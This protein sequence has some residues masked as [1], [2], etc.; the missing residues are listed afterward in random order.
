M[1]P[2]DYDRNFSR[3]AS[4]IVVSFR[5]E[6]G[7]EVETIRDRG[8]GSRLHTGRCLCSYYK[9]SLT[10]SQLRSSTLWHSIVAVQRRRTP[11]EVKSEFRSLSPWW[12]R[13]DDEKGVL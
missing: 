9:T 12:C 10:L 1:L 4:G 8:I 11:L 2:L 7:S 3:L 5:L 6:H 13:H